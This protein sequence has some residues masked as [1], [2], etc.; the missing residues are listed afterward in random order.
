[1][2]FST[3]LKRLTHLTELLIY[4]LG[5]R[6]YKEVIFVTSTPKRGGDRDGKE[7]N[8]WMLLKLSWHKFKLVL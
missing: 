5:H 8:F 2:L 6:V 1:M 4:V 3:W 7:K